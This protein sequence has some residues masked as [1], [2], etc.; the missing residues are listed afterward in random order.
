VD[1]HDDTLPAPLAGLAGL[2]GLPTFL[3]ARV[4]LEWLSLLNDAVWHRGKIPDAAS[5]PV[6]LVP[7]FMAT[8]ASM[9]P[10]RRWLR[11]LGLNAE[12]APVGLN[13]RPSAQVA[14]V[15]LDSV[16]RMAAEAG[17]RVVVIGHSR[18]GQHGTVAAVRAPEAVEAVVTL[19][20]PLRAASANHL[21]VRLPVQVLTTIGELVATA[22]QE[23]EEAAYEQDLLGPF[24]A[25]VRRV[26]V[27]SKSD[28]IVDWRLSVVRGARN[29]QVVG[30]HIGLS[31]NPQ[32]YRALVSILERPSRRAERRTALAS[33]PTGKGDSR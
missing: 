11:Q 17:Q 20:S 30:S 32:V 15:V 12:I 21:L 4:P 3:E 2:L 6:L 31:G 27:W 23:A 25:E 16:R 24:P 19:G 14:Q 10:M 1:A 33:Q 13:A 22:S 18:G 5:R 9:A 8:E 26:S 28:G 29:V 7:G